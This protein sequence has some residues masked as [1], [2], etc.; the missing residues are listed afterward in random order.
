M[1]IVIKMYGLQPQL[2]NLLLLNLCKVELMNLK[3][4]G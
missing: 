4:T 3:E 2:E 1:I